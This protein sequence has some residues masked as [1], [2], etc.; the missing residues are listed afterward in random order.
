[1]ENGFP[2]KKA[3][4][5]SVHSNLFWEI[6]QRIIEN[7]E[8]KRFDNEEIVFSIIN[9]KNSLSSEVLKNREEKTSDFI[10]FLQ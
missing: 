9:S 6:E 5:K 4:L 8:E 10:K 2:V 3:V 7:L 1:M